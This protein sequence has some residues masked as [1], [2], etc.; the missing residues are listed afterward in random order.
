MT[1]TSRGLEAEESGNELGESA[2]EGHEGEECQGRVGA[3][4]SVC[5]LGGCYPGA[6]CEGC[7]TE[8]GGRSDGLGE[9]ADLGVLVQD[10][11]EFAVGVGGVVFGCHC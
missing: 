11:F 6:A 3:A 9:D 1:S 8:G 4:P 7:E 5:D 10:Y 2:E